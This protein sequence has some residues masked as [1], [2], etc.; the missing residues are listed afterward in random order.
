MRYLL[1]GAGEFAPEK[2]NRQVDDIVIAVD[3]GFDFLSGKADFAIGDFDSLGYI[4]QVENVKVLPAHKDYTDMNMAL[5]YVVEQVARNH[6]TQPIVCIFGAL[7]GR[8]DHTIS[9]IQLG[10]DYSKRGLDVRLIGA[11]EQIV[12]VSDKLVLAKK[13]CGV[14][15]NFALDS[16]A[17]VS[18]DGFAYPLSNATLTNRFPLGQSNEIVSDL[19][20]ISVSKGTIM[21]IINDK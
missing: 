1:V 18:L 13:D 8:L 6:Q 10:Y 17:I 11:R 3:K 15:S 16:C 21:V 7:G 12:F 20:T 2:F 9:N 5:E 14:V 4:P 19:A